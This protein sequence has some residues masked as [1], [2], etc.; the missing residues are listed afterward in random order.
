MMRLPSKTVAAG[1]VVPD[2]HPSIFYGLGMAGMIHRL[3]LP[4]RR[5][6]IEVR[7]ELPRHSMELELT[8]A[9][10]LYRAAGELLGNVLRHAGARTVVV[11]LTPTNHGV[12]LRISDDG[13]GFDALRAAGLKR[14]DRGLRRLRSTVEFAGGRFRLRSAPGA[15]TSV[16]IT[17]PR[18]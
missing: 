14:A 15:G 5:Q 17:L 18:N 16:T 10:L 12:Q 7:L 13:T 3:T 2:A 6:G 1:P 11:R 4:L 8:A 9:V